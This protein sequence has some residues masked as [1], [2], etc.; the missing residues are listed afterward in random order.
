[1]KAPR[2]D[3]CRPATLPEALALLDCHASDAAV[4]AGGQ[5]LMPMLN[6]RVA[7]PAILIDINKIPQLDA[8]DCKGGCL[9]IGARARHNDVLRS[10]EVRNNAPLLTQALW[11][12]AHEAVRNRGTLG[13]SLALADPAAE[14]PACAV[15]LDADIVVQSVRGERRIAAG[16][17]FQGVYTTAVGPDELIS[18]VDFP[19]VEPGWQFRFD[20]IS[21][22]HGDF[23][24]AGLAIGIK[25]SGDTV[26]DCRI[27]FAGV[28]TAPRR[29]NEIEQILIGAKP[30]DESVTAAAKS[31]LRDTLEIRDGG[32][33]PREYRLHV[34]SELL[35]RVLRDFAG[36][37]Q[38]GGR[39]Q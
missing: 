9:S 13:G 37:E 14:L 18:R 21:R 33:F 20:E 26:S 6:F 15:C 27:V 29:L 8:I 25:C 10:R 35:A 3:Y 30:G 1:M 19:T 38:T 31:V 36:R 11:H 22:R 7:Q 23:A 24:I 17:F 4:L 5:S 2:F 34:A 39:V 28:E 16:E 32:E 12:V